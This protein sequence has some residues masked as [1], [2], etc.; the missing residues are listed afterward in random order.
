MISRFRHYYW[1]WS[2]FGG[3]V[4]YLIARSLSS[5]RYESERIGLLGF[6]VVLMAFTCLL[7]RDG[8]RFLRRISLFLLGTGFFALLAFSPVLPQKTATLAPYVI[9]GIAAALQLAD[10]IAARLNSRRVRT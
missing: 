7:G 10:L 1:L 8:T 2:V 5:D 3:I 6:I 9:I 4:S